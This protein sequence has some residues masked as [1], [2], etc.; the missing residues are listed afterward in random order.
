MIARASAY[1]VALLLAGACVAPAAAL[2]ASGGG[3]FAPA[4]AATPSGSQPAAATTATPASGSQTAAGVGVVQAGNATVTATGDGITIASQASGLLR[5]VLSF[6]GTLAAST[7]GRVVEIERLGPQT[8][9]TWA[10]T[11]HAR[12]GAGGSFTVV[13]RANHIGRFQFRP[14]LSSGTGSRAADSPP[15]VTVTVYRPSL[16]TQYGPGFYGDSTACGITLR[17]GTLGVANRSLPCGTLVAIYYGGR[18]TVVPVIDRGPFANG[19]DWDLTEATGRVLGIAGTATI[20]AVSL[21]GA[22]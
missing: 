22:P 5:S 16:A 8:N 6:K 3:G 19:A 4:L 20:G 15:T 21:P 11:A 2:A 13:W 12:V 10:P 7:A 1:A 9:W 18:A 14:V 17:R